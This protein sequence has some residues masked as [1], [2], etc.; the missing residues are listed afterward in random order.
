MRKIKEMSSSLQDLKDKWQQVKAKQPEAQTAAEPAKTN[1][2]KKKLQ[3]KRAVSGAK[4]A[5]AEQ[6]QELVAFAGRKKSPNNGCSLSPADKP[7]VSVGKNEKKSSG[8]EEKG[9]KVLSDSKKEDLSKKKL[10]LKSATVQKLSSLSDLKR[11]EVKKSNPK[12]EQPKSRHDRP[13]NRMPKE[14]IQGAE[15]VFR[16]VPKKLELA[17]NLPVSER[18]EDIREAIKNN[19][20]VIVSG[21]TGSG[22]TTQLPKICLQ[23]GRGQKGLIGHTQPR[24]IAAT[25][26]SKRIAEEMETKVGEVAGYQ[27]RFKDEIE[28]GASIK[29][30]TDGILLAETQTDPLLKKYDT[31][32][33]DE[34]HERSLNIDF[35]LGYLRQIMPKRPDLKVIIT[36][37]TIDSERFARHF[38]KVNGKPVPVINVSGRLYPVQIRYRPVVDEDENDDRT[39]MQAVAEACDELLHSGPGDIL[40]FLPGEREIREAADV[41]GRNSRPGIEILPLFSRLTIEEQDRVFRPG[42]GRRIVLATNIAE[43]SIT[44]PGIRYVV[45]SG[46]GRVKRYSYRNKVEQLQIEPISQAAAQ[47]RAGRCGRVSNGICIRLYDEKDFEKRPKY[48]DPEILR[49]SLASVILRMKSLHLSDVREF[50]FVQPPLPKAITDGYDLLIELN[51]VTAREGELTKIGR[52][53]AKLPVDAKVARMLQAAQDNQ[54][55]SEVLVIASAIS[56]QDPRE[57]PLDKQQQA[58]QSHKKFSDDKSDFLSYLKI[59]NFAQEAIANKK[60]NRLLERQFQTNFLSARRLREW[61]DVYRQ[62]KEMVTELGWRLNT[63]PATY[64][65]LHKSLLSGLLGNIGTRV[66]EPDWRSPPFVGAR[67]IKFWPWPGSALAKKAGKWIMASEIVETSRLYAR[68]IAN[69]EPEWLEKVGSHLIKKSWSDPHWEKNAG[70][71]IAFEKGTLYGLPVYGQRRVNF[72]PKDPKLAREI[73]IREALVNE[74]FESQAPFWQHNKAL[75]REIREMEHKSRRPDV[76][77]DD[78]QI[79]SFYDSRIGPDVCSIASLDKW[80]KEKEAEDPKILFLSKKDL[81][82]HDA[83]GITIEYFPKKIEAAGVPMAVN[84]NFDPGSPRDGVTI[85]VPLF[86]L[87]QISEEQMEWLVPGMVKEKTAA[88][89]KSLPQ[90]LRRHFV[91]IPDWAKAFAQAHETPE[92]SLL[93]AISDEAAAQ[94]RIEIKKTDFK[95]ENLPPHLLMNY[96]VVDEHGR[97][98]GMDRSLPKL[99]SEFSQQAKNYFQQVALMDSRVAEDLQE[100]FEDWSFGELPDIMEIRRKGVSLIGHPA[101]VDRGDFCSIEVFD[102]PEEAKN[103]HKKGLKKLIRLQLKE[104]IKYLDKSLKSLQSA[105]IIGAS[106]PFVKQAFESLENLKSQVI[107]AAIE[108]S[109]LLGKLPNNKEEFEVICRESKAKLNLIALEISKLIEQIVNQAASVNQKL[110]AFKNIKELNENINSQLKEMFSKNFIENKSINILRNYPRYLK[111][112]EVRLE[113]YRKDPSKDKEKAEEINKLTIKLNRERASRKGIADPRLEEFDNLLQELRVSLFAQELRTPIPVSIK[114]LNKFW[115]SIIASAGNF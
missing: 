4:Q 65:Q 1:F 48:T 60:S 102:E 55:L 33:I 26:I 7:F 64:E 19:Q 87:N 16:N 11:V 63:A 74:N 61:R 66:V 49:S 113:K 70:N 20:V 15:E 108:Q 30:M 18:A 110:N 13:A 31:I 45:D 28:R 94:F 14:K 99:R 115:D 105:Q 36:S 73:F 43:T 50:P 8:P 80:R 54:A 93:E 53:L 41:L 97:Q 2:A 57:R 39:L 46:L 62:L 17:E 76:L 9:R 34:A 22:K 75:I 32:I 95:V 44:V 42:A 81:M 27:I 6:L 91:P 90:R 21:E 25:S 107:N 82:R 96:K 104:Q 56:V 35:L 114:R 89:L 101:I 111:A 10:P 29:L 5:T 24:R 77:V 85:T 3:P 40:V 88:L 69:I 52:E 78:E 68:T 12:Q 58:D 79:F 109:C 72:A 38:E 59:W 92:G 98:I 103:Y 100:K 84:Y 67:G 47:Q 86:A 71:V 51:A 37:A 112:V 83:S 106:L 23:L